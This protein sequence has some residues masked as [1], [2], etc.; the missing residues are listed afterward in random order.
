M[1]DAMIVNKAS[2]ERGLAAGSV[3]KSDFVELPTVST[4]PHSFHNNIEKKV[5]SRAVNG[6]RRFCICS[7]N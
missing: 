5:K 6:Y 3:L 1:E 7:A 4:A 2:I